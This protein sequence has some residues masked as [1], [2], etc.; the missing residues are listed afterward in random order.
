MLKA[1]GFSAHRAQ[2]SRRSLHVGLARQRLWMAAAVPRWHI[3]SPVLLEA[4]SGAQDSS[5]AARATPE[6]FLRTSEPSCSM[7]AAEIPRGMK[8]EL[9]PAHRTSSQSDCWASTG[10]CAFILQR[11]LLTSTDY[12]SPNNAFPGTSFPLPASSPPSDSPSLTQFPFVIKKK[13]HCQLHLARTPRRCTKTS[14]HICHLPKLVHGPVFGVC[15]GLTS[16][17]CSHSCFYLPL[18]LF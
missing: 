7:E 9:S 6:P 18:L 12:K 8:A 17:F 4:P 1:R 16:S 5:L 10:G 2:K 3:T 13:E 11:A 15:R 14:F